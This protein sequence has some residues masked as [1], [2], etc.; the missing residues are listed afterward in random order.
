M[1]QHNLTT[2][3]RNVEQHGED[4]KYFLLDLG[5]SL[6][7]K[8]LRHTSEPEAARLT[9]EDTE[10]LGEANMLPLRNLLSIGMR[11]GVFQTKEG[12]P[13]FKPKH[14][15]DPQPSEFAISRIYAPV[16]Q[17]SPRLRW[18][19]T[20]TCQALL[21]LAKPG[22]RAQTMQE[23][24]ATMVRQRSANAAQ[25]IQLLDDQRR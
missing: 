24:K 16:L 8:L 17:L 9:I 10:M 20:V 22:K 25:Q 12:L 2:L 11:E 4:L 14:S 1:S 5:D 21:G 7:Y 19:T 18:R 23:L 13:A 3:S 6:R 15:S